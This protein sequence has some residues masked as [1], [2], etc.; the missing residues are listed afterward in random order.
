[1]AA[2]VKPRRRYDSPR[3][4]QQALQTRG[5]ILDGAQRLFTERG[6]TAT[7]MPAIAD[8]AGVALKTVYLAF[9][10]KAGV[11]HALWDVRLGGDDQPIPIVDR[12]WY[13]RLLQADDPRALLRTAA[14][15]SRQT[16]DRAG[17]VMRIVRHAAVT[18]P[19]IADL[20][21]RIET[22][23]RTVLGGFAH[24][25]EELGA[26]AG[27]IDVT[28]ATDILWTLNH[29]DTWYLLVHRCGWTADRYEQWVGDT[30]L[31]QLLGHVDIDP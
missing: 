29:P 21:Q 2:P 4:R 13:R 25:L 23:F 27:G 12:P 30:L 3:R 5:A 1:M 14:R 6:Y 31:T 22:E 26:L 17:E 28:A 16:K 11:L 18:D 9:G 20:W 15:Q 8:Q 24:R 19:A 10:T 7:A